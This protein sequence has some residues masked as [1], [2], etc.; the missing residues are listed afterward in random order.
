LNLADCRI[1]GTGKAVFPHGTYT[2]QGLF[3]LGSKRFDED[4]HPESRY[5]TNVILDEEA[6][7]LLDEQETGASRFYYCSRASTAEKNEGLPL[8]TA[9]G[10]PCAKPLRLCQY[11]ATLILPP[12]RETPRRLLVPFCGSGSEIIGA[13]LAGWDEVVGIETNTAYIDIAEYR[14]RHWVPATATCKGG[15]KW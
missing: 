5:P 12:A 10:H 11:L 9:N 8:G 3:K 14:I 7:R 15:Q 1:P 13:L 6:A 4:L 2:S